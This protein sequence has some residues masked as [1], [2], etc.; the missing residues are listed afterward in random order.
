[1]TYNCLASRFPLNTFSYFYSPQAEEILDD[2]IENM[3][4]EVIYQVHRAAKTGEVC[5]TCALFLDGMKK[6]DSPSVRN[7]FLLMI[8][9]APKLVHASL[10]LSN[11]LNY[12]DNSNWVD[13]TTAVLFRHEILTSFGPVDV[14]DTP[15]LDLFGQP[16]RTASSENFPCLHCHRKIVASRFA[17][18]LEKVRCYDAG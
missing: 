17:P 3:S 12:Q 14:I 10:S 16:I 15:G 11:S 13:S 8:L 7:P 4:L 2:L 6:R 1:M 9:P 18:H 5:G